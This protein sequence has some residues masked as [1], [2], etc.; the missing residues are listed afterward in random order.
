MARPLVATRV[1]PD[2]Y[3]R[4]K[5]LSGEQDRSVAWLARKAIEVFLDNDGASRRSSK[6][7]G[8]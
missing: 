8:G 4:L 1:D 6:P 5:E 3:R 2:A 7:K